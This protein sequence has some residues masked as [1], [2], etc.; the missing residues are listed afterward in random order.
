MTENLSGGVAVI[1]GAAGEIGRAMARSFSREGMTVVLSD[2]DTEA[3]GA[4][5][6]EILALGGNAVAITADVSDA[7]QVARLCDRVLTSHGTPAVVCA[8]AGVMGRFAELWGQHSE[9]WNWVFRVNVFGV[10][11]MVRGLVPAMI[12]AGTPSHFVI[13]GSDATYAARPYVAVYHATKHALGAIAEGLAMELSMIDAPVSVHL[14]CPTG[15]KS[16]R[17]LAHDRER[18]RPA[19]LRV[20]DSTPHPLGDRLLHAYRSHTEKQSGDDVAAALMRGIREDR[21]YIWPDPSILDMVKDA[22]EGTLSGRTPRLP[23]SFQK[24]F[25]EAKPLATT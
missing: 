9:D 2:V 25:A 16:P 11:G 18:L 7:R 4:A 12:D 14:V 1:T 24:I 19:E 10:L 20:A 5:Q 17:L 6:D 8:N 21:F 3:L 13:T 22:Y 15:V 23:D